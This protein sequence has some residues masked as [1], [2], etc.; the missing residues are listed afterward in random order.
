VA[1]LIMEIGIMDF[2]AVAHDLRNPLN[3][4]LG[5]VRLLAVERLSDAGRERLQ[6]LEAQVHRMMRLLDTCGDQYHGE[7]RVAPVDPGVLIANV[8]AELDAVLTRQGIEIVSTIDGVLPFVVADGDLLHR[9]LLNVMINAADA[10]AGRG[11][12]EIGARLVESASARAAIVH[13]EIAD[14]GMGIPP[15]LIPRVFDLGFTT[16]PSGES[17][18]LGLSICREIIQMHGGDIQL[19]SEPGHG[20]TVRLSLPVT[21]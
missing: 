17:R 5:H 3:V 7:P 8:V 21:A 10:I 15:E 18:G 16:K 6:V 11:R 4:M 12:I 20:T 2:S 19:S 13:I 9:V 1:D 14:T